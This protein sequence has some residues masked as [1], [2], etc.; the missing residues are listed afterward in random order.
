MTF[1]GNARP[2]AA[3]ERMVTVS[4]GLIRPSTASTPESHWDQRCAS[5]STAHTWSGLA[6][7]VEVAAVEPHV[8]S[9]PRSQ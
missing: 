9:C 8:D 7:T 1:N 5:Q 4:P 2:G 3:C 6:D